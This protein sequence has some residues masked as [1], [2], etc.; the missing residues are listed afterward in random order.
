MSAS[1]QNLVAIAQSLPAG[2]TAKVTVMKS[3]T[4]RRRR[5]LLNKTN[6]S[7]RS[8][9]G[10]HDTA[11]GSY[12]ATGDIAIGAGRMGTLNPVNSLGRAWVG[13]KD[14]NARRHAAVAGRLAIR[15]AI[16]FR[17]N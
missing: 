4:T 10:S 6:S 3:A 13:D 16:I 2:V 5:S 12:V 9:L 11:K 14:A 8:G 15:H 17:Y 1:T 7:G